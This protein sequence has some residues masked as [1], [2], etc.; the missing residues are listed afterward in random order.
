M[1]DIFRER[2]RTSL[3]NENLQ[4]A[5]DANAERRIAARK[6]ALDSLPEDWHVLRKRAHA[7][8]LDTIKNLD[9]YL[10]QFLEKV[11]ANGIQ[12]HSVKDATQAVEI[13]SD[14]VRDKGARLIVKSKTMVSEEIELKRRE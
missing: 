10:E 12:V 7:I 3:A 6:G 2:I 5:L 1:A 8:R 4:I 14:I 9:G 11:K 13:V